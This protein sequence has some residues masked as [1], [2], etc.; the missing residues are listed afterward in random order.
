[1]LLEVTCTCGWVVR[2]TEDE[3]VEQLTDHA[4]AD[5]NV[6]LTREAILAGAQQVD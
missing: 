3:I 5:H 4:W 2:G 6:R 1:M